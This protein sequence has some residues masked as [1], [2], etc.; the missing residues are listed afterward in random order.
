MMV[1]SPLITGAFLVVD[2][3]KNHR[4]SIESKN[5]SLHLAGRGS[6][7]PLKEHPERST[8]TTCIVSKIE[9][10]PSSG[11]RV[12]AKMDESVGEGTWVMEE[13]AKV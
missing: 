8:S 4:D 6:P 5:R 1:M 2:F 9:M 10:L 11:M 13:S 12:M 7:V 3:I